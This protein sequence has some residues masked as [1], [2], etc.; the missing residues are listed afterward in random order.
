MLP[1]LSGVGVPFK[2]SSKLENKCK[3]NFEM[4]VSRYDEDISWTRNYSEFRTV[5]NKGNHHSEYDYVKLENKGHLADTL[6]RHIINNYENLA[7]VTFFTHGSINYRN[8]QI[9]KENGACR[10]KW[11]DFIATD[12]NTL[13]YIP[14]YD[15]PNGGDT[16]YGYK[17]NTETVYV[18]IFN[19][20]YVPNFAWSCG[21]WI[22][23]SRSQ[24]RNC[25]KEVYQ[26][27]LDFV[28]EPHN[29]EEPSQEI[30][31][32]RGIFIERF[33][34]HAMVSQNLQL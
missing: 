5:Y 28:L 26:R 16:V 20:K 21:K 1:R 25:P 19:R 30:Y 33:I 22:S 4:V 3:T 2:M 10:R 8:D 17:D 27:M 15:L 7:D 14:R 34:I 6:L 12:S 24:I 23:A 13:V 18:R 9:I 32:T 31:R 29:G 11:S